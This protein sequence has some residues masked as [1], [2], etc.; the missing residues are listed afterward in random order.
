MQSESIRMLSESSRTV[1]KAPQASGRWGWQGL[2]G[3]GH[4]LQTRDMFRQDTS[5]PHL[6]MQIQ[7]LRGNLM[8]AMQ[9]VQITKIKN[10]YCV[11]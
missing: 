7:A 2:R 8:F 6:V 10:G 5:Q 11:R 9:S 3:Q 1:C 4:D